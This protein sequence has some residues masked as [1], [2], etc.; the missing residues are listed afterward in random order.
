MRQYPQVDMKSTYHV[1][2]TLKRVST[3]TEIASS[4]SFDNDCIGADDVEMQQRNNNFASNSIGCRASI[5]G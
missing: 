1:M 4:T 2:P 5:P 3:M